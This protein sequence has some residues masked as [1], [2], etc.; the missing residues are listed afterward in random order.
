MPTKKLFIEKD[1]NIIANV[2]FALFALAFFSLT[3]VPY[4]LPDDYYLVFLA[5]ILGAIVVSAS[6]FKMKFGIIPIILGVRI[7]YSLINLM[8]K[9]IGVD[10]FIGQEK[11]TFGAI[12]VFLYAYNFIGRDKSEIRIVIALTSL[13]TSMQIIFTAMTSGGDKNYVGSAIGMSNYAAT[14]LLICTIYYCF[15]KKT[16]VEIALFALGIVAFLITQSFG[17]Y[18]A[19]FV[20]LIYLAVTKVNWKSKITY[21]VISACVVCLPLIVLFSLKTGI[22]ASFVN[23]ILDKF[24]YLF[25]GNLNAFGSSRLELY[26]FSIKNIMKE[27]IFGIFINVDYT[28]PIDYRFQGFR[29]HNFVLESLLLYGIVGTLLNGFLLYYIFKKAGKNP[30]KNPVKKICFFVIILGLVHGFVEP[31]LFTFNYET[32]FW[33]AV[34]LFIRN[35]DKFGRTICFADRIASRI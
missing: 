27:P 31:N 6:R 26:G 28:L 16:P 21:I 1:K 17:G 13:M 15:I 18:I 2:S 29:T 11:V 35:E 30:L 22:G 23:K 9:G 25:T 19:F 3:V 33:T 5:F 32:F 4:F 24:A 8:G 10:L 7:V 20:L 34:G 12:L 14:V